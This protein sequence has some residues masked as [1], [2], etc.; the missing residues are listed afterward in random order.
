MTIF[1]KFSKTYSQNIDESIAVFGKDH[2]FFVKNKARIINN[3][4]TF[5]RDSKE[6]KV[7]D[8]GCGTGL[9]HK[10][11]V[12]KNRQIYGV[13]VSKDSIAVA[14]EANPS[15]VYSI[16]DGEVLPYEA[17]TFDLAYAI[18]VMHHV[19]TQQWANFVSEL[20]R[21]LKPG[22]VALVIEHNPF[23]PATQWV[24]RNSEL[25]IGAVLLKPRRLK[26]LFEVAG[27]KDIKTD[28]IQFTPFDGDFFRSLDGWLAAIPLG[29]QYVIKGTRG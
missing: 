25:D 8:V 13:D 26:G 5:E 10:Y 22:G 29:T 7:L 20:Y 1:D 23:N 16:Y 15:V 17:G 27:I 6:A 19:P 12:N 3:I 14:Q 21:V 4:I 2:N 24:V 28:Y 11:I 18:C 9:I